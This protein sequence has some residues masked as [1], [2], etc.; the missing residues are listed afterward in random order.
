VCASRLKLAALTARTLKTGLDTLG[1]KTV[2][3]M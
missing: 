1:I 2:E 3:R